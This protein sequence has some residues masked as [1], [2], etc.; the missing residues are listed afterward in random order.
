[1]SNLLKSSNSIRP[2]P[3]LKNLMIYFG[4]RAKLDSV[5][6]CVCHPQ[7]STRSHGMVQG[8]GVF[9]KQLGLDEV[10]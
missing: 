9:G 2:S 8:A 7:T 5:I 3:I 6:G 1:M 4:V 10:T